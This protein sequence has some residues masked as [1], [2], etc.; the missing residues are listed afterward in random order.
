MK[1]LHKWVFEFGF[2]V[3]LCVVSS[4]GTFLGGEVWDS[5][6]A[7]AC[8]RSRPLLCCRNDTPA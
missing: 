8:S 1:N 2:V 4:F 5:G 7:K 3:V 6:M